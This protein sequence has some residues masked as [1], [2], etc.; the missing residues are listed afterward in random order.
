MRNMTTTRQRFLQTV[1]SALLTTL[2]ASCG[3]DK[4]N[5]EEITFPA[6]EFT[7]AATSDTTVFGQQGTRLFIGK[8]IFQFTNGTPV[9]DSIKIKLNEFYKKADITLAGLSTESGGKLL[10]T[11]GML[12]ITAA[13]NGREIEIKSD[14]RMVVHFPKQQDSYKQM[15]LFYPGKGTT[16]TSVTNW[17]I[18]TVN[19]VKRTLK[20]GG[21]GWQ[22][23][24]M[25]DSTG[26]DFKP[27]NY[28]DTG[29]YW[30]PIDFYVSAYNFTEQTKKEI[31]ENTN[32]GNGNGFWTRGYGVECEMTIATDGKIRNLLV[33][34]EVS[35]AT[36]NELRSFLKNIPVLEP[37]KNKSGK[38][39]ERKGYLLI[40][41]GNIVPLYKTKEAYLKSFN[42]KYAK[43]EK[44]PIKNIDNAELEYY[45]FSVAKLGWINCDR[46]L[47]SE[48][49]TDYFVNT[50]EKDT[51]IKMVFKDID[52]VLMANPADGKFVFSKVPIGR[53]VTIVAIKHTNG[54]FQAAFQELTISDKP[55]ETL[56]FKE[57]TLAALKQQLEKLN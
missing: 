47:E 55:L 14:K 22:W 9:T 5:S 56:T 8:G 40:T 27:K 30:N 50:R 37:G 1:T 48:N 44:A 11:G 2:I 41:D 23:P 6:T 46:F 45:I 25:D 24:E 38:I 19:L 33:N 49:T 15:N 4:P 7:I 29:Y 36:K 57:M 16:D 39:I 52:G 13:S 17:D 20:L 51:K 21:Y 12:H 32:P 10:E 34:T 3:P 54:Q 35:T 42:S 53:Q 26:Y 43:Y 31:E 18:D 28:I